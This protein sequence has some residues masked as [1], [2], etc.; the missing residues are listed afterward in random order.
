[1]S[2]ADEQRRY[3]VINGTP[4]AVAAIGGKN[5]KIARH[6]NIVF[7][8]LTKEQADSLA[9]SGCEVE[10]VIGISPGVR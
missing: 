8:F 5:V 6:S 7:A 2:S 9:D 1:M 10:L 3:S 4:E